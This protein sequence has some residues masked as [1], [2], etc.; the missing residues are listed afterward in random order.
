LGVI[1]LDIELVSIGCERGFH[2]LEKRI[3]FHEL[4]SDG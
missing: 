3:H 2:I 1:Y 4:N